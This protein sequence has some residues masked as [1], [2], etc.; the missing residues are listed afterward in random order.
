MSI[1]W[2]H[3]PLGEQPDAALAARLGVSTSA[4]SQQRRHRGIRPYGARRLPPWAWL[5]LGL[6]SDGEVA[7]ACGMNCA[8]VRRRRLRAGIPVIEAPSAA[9]AKARSAMGVSLPAWLPLAV[10]LIPD[11][12]LADAAGLSETY[13]AKARRAWGVP[14]PER[15]VPVRPAWL[16]LAM[17]I[18]PDL[19]VANL[20][21]VTHGVVYK[22]RRSAGIPAAVCRKRRT[23]ETSS[24]VGRRPSANPWLPLVLGTVP[25]PV[26]ARAMGVTRARVQ[27]LRKRYGIPAFRGVT[28]E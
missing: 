4:V 24:R 27:Q 19:G 3:E 2:D 12:Q 10:G 9:G 20:A 14:P 16:P 21:G 7:R 5:V 11:A 6:A 23:A 15:P 17:G 8:Q 25:D 26:L 22:M 28:Q 18:I 1:D 13:V